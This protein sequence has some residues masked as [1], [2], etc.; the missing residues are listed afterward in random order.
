[1]RSSR[2]LVRFGFLILLPLEE[3]LALA[4][5]VAEPL[6]L[7]SVQEWGFVLMLLVA[8][9]VFTHPTRR[10]LSDRGALPGARYRSACFR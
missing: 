6:V 2:R 5:I 9:F 10:L 4:L 7:L 1:V 3:F 8:R